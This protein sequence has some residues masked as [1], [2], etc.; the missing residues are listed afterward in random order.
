MPSKQGSRLA[1]VTT[2]TRIPVHAPPSEIFPFS[3]LS[4]PSVTSCV[5]GLNLCVLAA[6][7]E[8]LLR[9][10]QHPHTIKHEPEFAQ[11]KP[12]LRA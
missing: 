10:L 2:A 3:G 6:L 1:N 7:R 11:A 5:K 4:F 12:G 9:R 8:I